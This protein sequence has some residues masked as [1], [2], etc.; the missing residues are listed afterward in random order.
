MPKPKLS[1]SPVPEQETDVGGRLSG[2][3]SPS[4]VA[5][6]GAA[7]QASADLSTWAAELQTETG[8]SHTCSTEDEEDDST[9]ESEDDQDED[10][11]WDT[12]LEIE[13]LR[14]SHDSAGRGTYLHTCQTY[15]VVPISYFLRHM[16]DSELTLTHHGLSPKAAK[17]LALS[18]TNNTSVVKLNLSDNWLGGEGT[19]AIAEMLKENCFIS[20]VDLSENRSGVHGAKAL[21]AALR[22]NATLVTLKLSG[23]E[24]NDEA[25][26]YLAEALVTN[27]K[28]ASLD[29]SHN[30]LGEAAGEVLGAAIAENV[31]LKELDLSWNCFRGQGAVAVAKGLGV[32]RNPIASK[33]CVGILKAVRANPG[34]VLEFLD[35]SEIVVKPDFVEL[36][37]AVQEVAPGLRIKHDGTTRLFRRDPAKVS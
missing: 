29:L 26:Q 13:E 4:E 28:L 10:E 14:K 21:S 32:P 8:K 7:S 3:E 2:S 33:G 16:K 5:R 19:A 9:G 22:A 1:L 35:F 37:A 12:D 23:N 34:T 30:R 25:A 36:C 6:S 15:G 24:L 20:D 11:E 18:L 17:A 27:H 31:G